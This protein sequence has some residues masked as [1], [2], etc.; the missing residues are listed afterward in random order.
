M[1]LRIVKQELYLALRSKSF[2]GIVLFGVC[3]SVFHVLKDILPNLQYQDP[4]STKIGTYPLSS[5]Q[6]W[7]MIQGGV[8]QYIYI[9]VVVLFPLLPYSL[10]QLQRRLS[11][12][13]IPLI[14]AVGIWRYRLAASIASGI[15]GAMAAIV[16]PF[17]DFILCCIFLPA[18]KPLPFLMTFWVDRSGPLADLYFTKPLLYVAAV[19]LLAGFWGLCLGFTASILLYRAKSSI[20]GI[21]IVFLTLTALGFAAV[22]LKAPSGFLSAFS[23]FNGLLFTSLPSYLSSWLGGAIWLVTGFVVLTMSVR[24]DVLG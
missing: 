6:K 23:P 9:L 1:L 8:A 24:R 10:A 17:S 19:T 3:L 11:G 20:A 15:S 18:L 5:Y 16:V 12:A 14:M 4:Q 13:E 7:V 21:G 22:S 2:L